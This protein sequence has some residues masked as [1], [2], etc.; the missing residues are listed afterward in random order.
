MICLGSLP[1]N[2]HSF[3]LRRGPGDGGLH[4]RK[5]GWRHEEAEIVQFIRLKVQSISFESGNKHTD[6]CLYFC[7]FDLPLVAHVRKT[8]EEPRPVG[9]LERAE[10]RGGRGQRGA[11]R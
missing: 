8:P 5:A 2:E 3:I 1:R 11:P 6:D 9:P 7:Q 10:F 4:A